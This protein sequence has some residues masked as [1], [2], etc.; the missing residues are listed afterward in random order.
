MSASARVRVSAGYGETRRSRTAAKAG[1]GARV[2][3]CQ[4][5]QEC[6]P[7]LAV[8]S[9]RAMARTRRSRI[10][11]KAGQGARGC[12]SAGVPGVSASARGRVSAGYGETR[13][14]RIAAKAGQGA[15]SVRCKGGLTVN[16]ATT[17]RTRR[18]VLPGSEALRPHSE[19]KPQQNAP[20]RTRSS[21]AELLK[22]SSQH[23]ESR[24]PS[25]E[26]RD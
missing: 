7:P 20:A 8:A 25:P 24:I 4:G 22:S 17:R 9:R 10:A 12:Q 5:C 1:Q 11:A 16:S 6:P 15:G 26:S 3:K 19:G 23:R 13:R 18:G 2:P 14:S 21:P